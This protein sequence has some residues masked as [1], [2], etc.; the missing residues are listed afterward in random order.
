MFL[1]DRKYKLLVS[2]ITAPKLYAIMFA[3]FLWSTKSILIEEGVN[4]DSAF[5]W[6]NS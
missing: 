4:T 6:N 2:Q 5:S 3:I 1:K